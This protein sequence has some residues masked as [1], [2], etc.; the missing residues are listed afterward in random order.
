[1]ESHNKGKPNH[2]HIEIKISPGRVTQNLVVDGRCN[3]ERA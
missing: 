1:M 3:A 2:I